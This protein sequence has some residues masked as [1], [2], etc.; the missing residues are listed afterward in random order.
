MTKRL[1]DLFCG[2]GGASMG[3][4]LAGFEVVGVDN[5]RQPNYPFGFMLA[6]ALRL[7][8][9]WVEQFDVIHASPPCL[10]R[11]AYKRRPHWVY[12]CPDLLLAVRNMLENSGKPW[13]MENLAGQHACWHSP[14]QLCGSSFGL[15]IRRHRWFE[16]SVPMMT[17]P[18]HHSWQT[19]RFPCAGN[20]TNLR[21]TIEI[22]VWRIP[23]A[24][25]QRAMEIDWM[26][27]PE[28]TKALPP[29]YTKFIGENVL[30]TL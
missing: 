16:S 24:D 9:D 11:T 29:A 30:A 2:A 4:K 10:H 18:C 19:P 20:R 27:K 1:L 22:G 17:P 25:Q 6:D 3:Y 23:L 15:D 8:Y 5:E 7:D 28:L 13:I 21:S 26:T 14:F 12:D